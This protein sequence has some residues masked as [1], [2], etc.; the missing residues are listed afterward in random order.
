[1]NIHLPIPKAV[2][3]RR[4]L[5]ILVAALVVPSALVTL[6]ASPAS[7]TA[8]SQ[9]TRYPYLTDV[10]SAGS[11]DNATVNF[12]TDPTITAAF[13]TIGPAGGSCSGTNRTGSKTG[14]TVNGVA[15][16]QWK[17]EVHRPGAGREL[18]LPPVLRQPDLARTRPAGQRPVTGVPDAARS[19]QRHHLQVRRVRRL[20]VPN[21]YG[22]NPDQANLM[23]RSQPAGAR[24]ML[25]V[26]DTGYTNGSQTN[27]GDLFQ[28]GPSISAVFAPDFF[29]N[30]GKQSRCSPRPATTAS[31]RRSWI[32]GRSRWLRRCQAAPIRWTPIA[33]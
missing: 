14:I 1:M 17:V 28:A 10:V 21:A 32:S 12:A 5:A 27:Y 31:T 26:G 20:G 2:R 23:A 4:R 9:L 18:L 33:A 3:H 15:E 6:G 16:N 13:A 11:S 22:P 7:A 25:G 8:A 30:V 19:G 24:F 29:K